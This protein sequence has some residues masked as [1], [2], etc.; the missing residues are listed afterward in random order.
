MFL[1][2]TVEMPEIGKAAHGGNVLYRYGS[3]TELPGSIRDSRVQSEFRKT[4]PKRRR[5]KIAESAP[6]HAAKPGGLLDGETF[7][8]IVPDVPYRRK[9]PYKII[10]PGGRRFLFPVSRNKYH[11]FMEFQPYEILP[12]I[13]FVL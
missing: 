12:A 1:K 6:A 3:G 5:K 7:I 10:R 2:G 13:G 4:L 8:G 9:K 11:E